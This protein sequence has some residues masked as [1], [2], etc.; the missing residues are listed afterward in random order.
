MRSNRADA[1]PAASLARSSGL[2]SEHRKAHRLALLAWR[3]LKHFTSKMAGISKVER[4][5][6]EAGIA[7]LTG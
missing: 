4:S 3:E 2:G 6:R 5:G 7:A 1:A